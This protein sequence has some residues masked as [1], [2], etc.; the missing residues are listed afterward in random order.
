MSKI[1]LLLITTFLLSQLSAQQLLQPAAMQQD[2]TYLRTALEDTHPGLYK[3]HSKKEMQHIMD[4][5]Y[6]RLDKPLPFFDFYKTIACLIAAVK[7]EHTYCNPYGDDYGTTV[8]QWKVMPLQLFF[9]NNK[10]YVLVNLTSDTTIHLGDEV[11]SINHRSIDSIKREMYPYLPADGNMETSKEHAISSLAFNI[12]Y[13][14]FIEHPDTFNIRIKN[15][16]GEAFNWHWTVTSNLG[17]SNAIAL[18]NPANKEILVVDAQSKKN[19]KIPWKLQFVEDKNT[20]ILT[21]H[22][23]S[24]D[25]KKLFA[26]YE[27][28]FN[29]LKSKGTHHL[30]VNLSNNG[31][32]DE[33]YAAE[34][35]SYITAVPMRFINEEYLINDSSYYLQQANLPKEVLAH[36][37]DY[38]QPKKEGK[39]LAKEQTQYTRELK[40]FMPKPNRFQGK[41]YFY[42]DGGTSSAASTC[43]AV[44]KSNHLATIVGT[45][46]AGC[47]AG[48]GST[49]GL[50]LTLPN[51]KIVAHTTIVYQ[52]FATSGGDKDRGV[53]P[54]HYFVPDFYEMVSG[55]KG[56]KEFIYNLT[57]Q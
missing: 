23:F 39:I 2:F 22:D 54:D 47:Y 48:G 26:F 49:I 40:L 13:Y 51:S 19:R 36:L 6:A 14:L 29:E 56:W 5:L 25:R 35:L 11:L 41:V 27:K 52:S 31:G 18:K 1:L 46:T 30:I 24:G 50:D 44:A 57:S 9:T 10:A 45:E 12:Y 38:L 43:A 53:L 7:C 16:Q 28:S 37:S 34:L 8:R 33:E 42:V 3:H 17:E 55:N 4:S 32:G 15:K 21:L 20:A